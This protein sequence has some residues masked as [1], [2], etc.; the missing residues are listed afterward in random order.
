MVEARGVVI[1]TVMAAL[2][3]LGLLAFAASTILPSTLRQQACQSG[4]IPKSECD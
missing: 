2:V 3:V 4:Q 1:A